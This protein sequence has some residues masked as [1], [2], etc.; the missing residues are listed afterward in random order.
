MKTIKKI[1]KSEWLDRLQA[2]TSG[3]KGRISA[4]VADGI[5]VVEN[6]ALIGVYYDPVG[7]GNDMMISIEGYSHTV[8]APVELN[9]TEDSNGVVS[10]LEIV[11][12][13]GASAFLRL[14]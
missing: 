1:I 13:N 9:I 2:F 10:T 3:N 5:T 4:I 7:K 14:D 8:Q 12:Q 6:K 11:D